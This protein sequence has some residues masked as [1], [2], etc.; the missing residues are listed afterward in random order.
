[1]HVVFSTKNANSAATGSRDPAKKGRAS[2]VRDKAFDDKN[3][4]R[5]KRGSLFRQTF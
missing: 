1:M 5:P 4:F 2:S 3:R